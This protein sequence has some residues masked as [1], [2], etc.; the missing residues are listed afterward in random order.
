MHVLLVF[1]K[2][3]DEMKH[4]NYNLQENRY[5]VT[6]I[7]TNFH[8]HN[9]EDFLFW[10]QMDDFSTMQGVVLVSRTL[11]LLEEEKSSL[12]L[13]HRPAESG[14]QRLNPSQKR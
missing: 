8:K 11:E 4:F 5:A 9:Q 3:Y 7:E 10:F 14:F 6:F 13:S 2:V 12:C 1:D